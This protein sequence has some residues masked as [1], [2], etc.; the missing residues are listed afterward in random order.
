MWWLLQ[1]DFTKF[2]LLMAFSSD[3]LTEKLSWL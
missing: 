3:A 2:H 1:I